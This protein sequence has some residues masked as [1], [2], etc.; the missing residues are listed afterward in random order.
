MSSPKNFDWL[1][2]YDYADV[3]AAEDGEELISTVG[4]VSPNEVAENSNRVADVYM[5]SF[6]GPASE[7][8]AR[9]NASVQAQ[10][11]KA[12]ASRTDAVTA[13]ARDDEYRAAAGLEALRT[14]KPQSPSD[15]PTTID[16]ITLEGMDFDRTVRDDIEPPT[17]D[18]TNVDRSGNVDPQLTAPENAPERY[19][20]STL[21]D[22]FMNA[23]GAS[24]IGTAAP[25]GAAIETALDAPQIL[26]RGLSG[27]DGVLS[28]AGQTF[29]EHYEQYADRFNEARENI[30]DT[31]TLLGMSS[32][33]AAAAP[34]LVTGALKL[35]GSGALRAVAANPV[36][37]LNTE[38]TRTAASKAGLVLDRVGAAAPKHTL[39][40]V[41]EDTLT[42]T[43]APRTGPTGVLQR[44]IYSSAAGSVTAGTQAALLQQEANEIFDDATNAAL[45]SAAMQPLLGDIAIPTARWLM[46][47]DA[48]LRFT[49]N[50]FDR[51]DA[52]GEYRA[53]VVREAIDN[54]KPGDTVGD[55]RIPTLDE[56]D[57]ELR[58]YKFLL[59]TD[60]PSTPIS[61][62]GEPEALMYA[63]AVADAQTTIQAHADEVSKAATAR[64]NSALEAPTWRETVRTTKSELASMV[65][66]FKSLSQDIP[67]K[68]FPNPL[69][70]RPV[71][72]NSIFN[73]MK[74][75]YRGKKR[76]SAAVTA[77][78]TETAFDLVREALS[79]TVELPDGTTKRVLSAKTP[80]AK[81]HN[82]RLMLAEKARNYGETGLDGRARADLLELVGYLDEQ[83]SKH[84]GLDTKALRG[85]YSAARNVETAY[86]LGRKLFRGRTNDLTTHSQ[87]MDF[88]AFKN[89]NVEEYMKA[90]N[91]ATPAEREAFS[92]GFLAQLKEHA[93]DNGWPETMNSLVGPPQIVR[94][95]DPLSVYKLTYDNKTG[96]ID[97]LEAI[98]GEK[99]TRELLEI[100]STEDYQ[101]VVQATANYMEDIGRG[102]PSGE[103]ANFDMFAKYAVGAMNNDKP[104]WIMRRAMAMANGLKT[105]TNF[106]AGTPDYIGAMKL[107][108]DPE[109]FIKER[110]HSA[111]NVLE[112]RRPIVGPR[113]GAT[114]A[115]ENVETIGAAVDYIGDKVSSIGSYLGMGG[116]EEVSEEEEQQRRIQ[117]FLDS[118]E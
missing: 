95:G 27:E 117:Q 47:D 54:L 79:T 102:K 92:N 110:L 60:L 56:Y 28:E 82:V 84:A 35:F 21:S 38:L 94:S 115:H 49:R 68:E 77:P 26:H 34:G 118:L 10:R 62:R 32:D 108:S 25:V 41:V 105:M 80:L 15:A 109:V 96:G 71:N 6:A 63:A 16:P 100:Y 65:P 20:P 89:A 13:A 69:G 2:N 112:N 43:G 64:R 46:S 81:L 8:V 98:L 67:S 52:P 93:A 58:L 86:E 61:A 36:V 107:L 97:K 45:W 37:N 116:E 55:L 76:Q 111:V 24:S 33:V 70:A 74:M 87:H 103:D 73:G 22:W 50:L 40:G 4:E 53:N 42:Y 57:N 23:I 83:I 88:A 1:E 59:D 17:W 11:A 72:A 5:K 39:L 75:R 113:V 104:N 14:V 51:V 18:Y 9:Y 90:A 19:R 7:N 44:L 48:A 114:G 3:P 101:K 78:S 12:E 29:G 30:Y 31:S 85:K 66:T 99:K 106:V 91:L